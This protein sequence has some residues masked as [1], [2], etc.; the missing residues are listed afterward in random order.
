VP[1][2]SELVLPT[3]GRSVMKAVLYQPPAA[4]TVQVKLAK[5]ADCLLQ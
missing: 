3:E 1:P 5:S 2:S 4:I